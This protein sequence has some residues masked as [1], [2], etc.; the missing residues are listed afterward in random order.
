MFVE[1]EN[2][3]EGLIRISNIEDDYYTFDEK[4][5]TMIGER[6]KRTFRI[7][8]VLKIRVDKV[9]VPNRNIDFMLV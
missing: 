7:G 1:L 4:H 3:I 6:T 2:T 8:D 9:D 5:Y